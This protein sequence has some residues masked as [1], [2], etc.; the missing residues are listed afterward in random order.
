MIPGLPQDLTIYEISECNIDSWILQLKSSTLF[1]ET[2][3]D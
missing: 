3:I 1:E 2:E